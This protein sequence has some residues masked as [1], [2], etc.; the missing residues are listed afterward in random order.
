MIINLDIYRSMARQR[1]KTNTTYYI[2]EELKEND[3][4]YGIL[5]D[6]NTLGEKTKIHMHKSTIPST[7][8]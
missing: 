6:T 8:T 2:N 4:P 1:S 3:E 5:G 7:M